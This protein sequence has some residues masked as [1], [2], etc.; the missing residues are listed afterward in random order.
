MKRNNASNKLY[1]GILQQTEEAQETLS[2]P[3]ST[4]SMRPG[5]IRFF[6]FKLYIFHILGILT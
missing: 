1:L 4:I 5:Q 3:R 6:V 2:T